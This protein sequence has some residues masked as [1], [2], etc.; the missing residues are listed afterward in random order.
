M[1]RY[2]YKCN[3]CLWVWETIRFMND[4]TAE[5]CPECNSH[6]TKKIISE[7]NFILKGSGFHDTDY[8]KH[9][10]KDNAKR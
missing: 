3:N 10:A 2:D 9:G 1:I 8:D 4:D 6:R 5:Q 7:V